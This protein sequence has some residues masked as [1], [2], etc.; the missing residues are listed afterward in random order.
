G[1]GDDRPPRARGARAQRARSALERRPDAPRHGSIEPAA[2]GRRGGR[3]A[4]VRAGARRRAAGRGGREDRCGRSGSRIRPPSV[5][6]RPGRV[7]GGAATI[8]TRRT[9]LSALFPVMK[10]YSAKPGEITRDWY[11]VD[12]E[13]KT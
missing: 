13:G 4:P 7:P 12:A 2:D 10:T 6:R 11:L 5:P 9:P 8:P 1:D 3:G